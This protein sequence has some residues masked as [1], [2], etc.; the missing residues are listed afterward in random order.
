MNDFLNRFTSLYPVWLILI[1][2]LAFLWPPSL[3]WFNGQWI[4][5]ALT[6]VMLGMGFTLTIDDFR[7]LLKMPGCVTLG[8]LAQ[9]TIMPLA[10]W[11]VA[12]M[13]QLEPGFAVGLILVG[14]CPGGTASNV[15]TYL[16]K[17]DVALSVIL[18]MASTLLAFVMTPLWCQILAGQYVPV[19]AL[20]LCLSTLQVVVAPVLIGVFCNWKFPRA[21]AHVAWLG[22][23]V[24]VIA[25][26][27]I[28]GGIVAVS[29]DKMAQNAVQLTTAVVLLHV[30]GFALGYGVSRLF[31]F[32]AI[33][34]RT[35]SIEV[36]M[37]N[38]GMAAMLART[39]FPLHPLAAVPAV[40]SGI[41][42]N[43]LGSLLAAWWRARPV[44]QLG[45]ESATE[46]IPDP[47]AAPEAGTT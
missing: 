18:T 10:A 24:S 40:F 16:A 39:H 5:W 44:P 25:I 9:Y 26:C 23:L 33:V 14:S 43:L 1:S 28:T 12:S 8:F 13:L 32:P 29:A 22:P 34:A 3:A 27:L 15:V 17:A 47:V 7:R 21:V 35:V 4:V 41:M 2:A 19:D 31:R 6:I 42:Q 36:G 46:A 11:S 45:S 30:I 38:G 20:G 37:Q